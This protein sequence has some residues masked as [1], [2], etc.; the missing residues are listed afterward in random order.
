MK[1]TKRC[2]NNDE[3][4]GIPKLQRSYFHNKNHVLQLRKTMGLID[5]EEVEARLKRQSRV[6]NKSNANNNWEIKTSEM[7]RSPPIYNVSQTSKNK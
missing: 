1:N 2:L 6:L 3:H 7:L 5:D 4:T